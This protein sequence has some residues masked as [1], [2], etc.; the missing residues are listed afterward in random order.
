MR[1]AASA[2][3]PPIGR[4]HRSF[5][6]VSGCLRERRRSE[7]SQSR[8]TSP[9]FERPRRPSNRLFGSLG[10]HDP[11][12]DRQFAGMR[13]LNACRARARP[14]PRAG[15]RSDFGVD[16]R[17]PARGAGNAGRSPRCAGGAGNGD[18]GRILRARHPQGHRRPEG[19]FFTDTDRRRRIAALAGARERPDAR[20][21]CA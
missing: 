4:L 9:S 19:R 8:R 5:S 21:P 11:F 12:D 13:R 2:A 18:P 20:S 1:R 17:S 6:R 15:G 10:R 14:R 16:R 3:S 7:A